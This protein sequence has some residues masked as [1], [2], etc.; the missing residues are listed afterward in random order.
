[1]IIIYILAGLAAVIFLFLIVKSAQVNR[2]KKRADKEL[3]TM[4]YDKLS[5][6]GAVKTL[7]ILPLIDFYSTGSELKTEPGVSYLV[8]ADDT[9]ILLD[10]GYNAKKEHPSPLLL[11]M[12]KLGVTVDDIDMLFISHPH[13][14]HLGGMK[15]Q[16]DKQF[17]FSQGPVPV[18]GIPVYAPDNV[19]PSKWNPHPHVEVVTGPKVIKEGIMSIGPIP[20][21]LFM[22]GYTLEHSLAV[23]VEGKGIVLIVGCG[24]QTVERIIE[25]ATS[26]FDEP[27]YGIIGGLHFPVHG[28]RIML[29]PLNLQAIVG[30]DT[31][32]WRGIG[33]QDV[34]NSIDVIKWEDPHIVSLSAHD[35]SDWSIARFKEAF[36]DRYRDLR[37]GEEIT[38]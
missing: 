36:G 15:E 10:V 30:S 2:G 6:V 27:I 17:S 34:M 22:M 23:N 35:S 19:T 21:F 20:R 5:P 32:P 18:P 31:P 26:L 3:E 24:H 33:E 37:V 7:S 28:G 1:M 29:G 8:K 11:N 12:E 14:D 9:T 13:V 4:V 16:K 38:I 25:R